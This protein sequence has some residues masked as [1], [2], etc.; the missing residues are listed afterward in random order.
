MVYVPKQF[1]ISLFIYLFFCLLHWILFSFTILFTT[2]RIT[3]T[4]MRLMLYI[5]GFNAWFLRKHGKGKNCDIKHVSKITEKELFFL[6]IFYFRY[7]YTHTAYKSNFNPCMYF[8]LYF[9][10]VLFLLCFLLCF[11]FLVFLFWFFSVC[12]VLFFIM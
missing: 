8:F 5:V 4:S 11:F 3:L 1:L 10:H 12:N 6:Y 2:I 7:T 9:F